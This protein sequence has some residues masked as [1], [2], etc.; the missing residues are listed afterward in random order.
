MARHSYECVAPKHLLKSHSTNNS[1]GAKFH[2]F[3]CIDF[4]LNS[5]HFIDE[6]LVIILRISLFVDGFKN[7][8]KCIVNDVVNV[9]S[10]FRLSNRMDGSKAIQC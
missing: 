6:L 8:Y 10:C 1:I 2:I 4:Y 7:G 3:Q 5:H 9:T